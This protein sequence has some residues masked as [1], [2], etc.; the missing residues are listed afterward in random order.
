[1]EVRNQIPDLYPKL[2]DT[3]RAAT[4]VA[5]RCSPSGEC[6][7]SASGGTRMN[8]ANPVNPTYYIV[9]NKDKHMQQ[10][11]QDHQGVS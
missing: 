6:N 5:R 11:Y 10:I 3:G 2:R 4:E 7:E 1:M 8:E 9:V